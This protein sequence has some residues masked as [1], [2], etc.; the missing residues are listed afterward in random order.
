MKNLCTTIG[1]PLPTQQPRGSDG[2]DMYLLRLQQVARSVQEEFNRQLAAAIASIAAQE[3]IDPDRL[4][5]E[6][7][8][9]QVPEFDTMAAVSLDCAALARVTV[10][11][12]EGCYLVKTSYEENISKEEP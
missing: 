3:Q 9:R 11:F 10:S 7:G 8:P 12:A 1:V 4:Y 5:I 6:R 2:Q